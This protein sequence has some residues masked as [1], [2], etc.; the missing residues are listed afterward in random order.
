MDQNPQK[1]GFSVSPPPNCH[2]LRLGGGVGSLPAARF[3][4]E[5]FAFGLALAFALPLDA[6]LAGLAGGA[7]G[8]CVLS[9]VFLAAYLAVQAMY[10]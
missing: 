3:L 2:A 10:Y 5:T 6:P 7:F 8:V 1:L 9:T 4:G